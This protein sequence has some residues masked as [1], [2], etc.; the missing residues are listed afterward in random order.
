MTIKLSVANGV[1]TLNDDA[2]DEI[3]RAVEER[4]SRRPKPETPIPEPKRT[5]LHFGYFGAPNPEFADHVTYQFAPGW[6]GGGLPLTGPTVLFSP[7]GKPLD[8]TLRKVKE[9][10]GL[11]HIIAMYPI[12]EPDVAGKSDEEATAIFNAARDAARA[13]G[14]NPPPPIMVCYGA[15]GFPGKEAADIIGQDKY[16]QGPF[17]VPIRPDQKRFYIPGVADPWR[18]DPVPFVEKALADPLAWGIVTFIWLDQWGGESHLGVHGNGMAVRCRAAY[19]MIE[20]AGRLPPRAVEVVD[21]TPTEPFDEQFYLGKYPDVKAAIP[22]YFSS[23]WDHYN[24]HGRAEGRTPLP[25]PVVPGPPPV[26]V[27]PVVPPP[28]EEAQWNPAARYP[29]LIALKGA[30]AMHKYPQAVTLDGKEVQPGFGPAINFYTWPDSIR[31]EPTGAA[32]PSEPTRRPGDPLKQSYASI[33]DLLA[34]AKVVQWGWAIVVD[35]TPVQGGFEADF[36][37]VYKTSGRRIVHV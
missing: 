23:G 11:H 13:V 35:G 25:P 1:L 28:V 22:K 8:E 36:P 27:D 26:P 12:D 30:L 3:V 4:L 16:G 5:P 14:L 2:L 21:Q 19:A 6:D 18:E 32:A 31:Q 37:A 17:T 15:K 20:A 24:K 29:S 34:D 33:D 7:F 10:G 9:Q